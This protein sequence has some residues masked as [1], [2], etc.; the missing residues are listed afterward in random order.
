MTICYFGIYNPE[1]SRNRV[2]IKGL[3]QNSV[4][5][6]EC[7]QRKGF[8]KYI[9]LFLKHW[10]IRNSYDFMIVGFP[11]QSVVWLAR[12]ISKKPII[13]DAFASIYDSMVWDRKLAKPKSLK[14]LYYWFLD[15][16]SCHLADKILLDTQEHI[17]Y[18]IETFHLDPRKFYRIFVGTDEDIFYPRPDQ[19]GQDN[20]FLVHF[21]G[22]FIPLQGIEYIIKAAKILEKDNIKFN[23]IGKGQEYKKVIKLAND[24]NV[25][26]INFIDP[27]PY[28]K[29]IDYMAKADICLGIFGDTAKTRRVIPNKLYESLA[30][31]KAVITSNTKAAKELLIDKENCLLS[32][33][34]DGNSLAEKILE[35][36]NGPSLRRKIAQNG[37]ELF[38]RNATS[39]ILG[40]KL[41]NVLTGLNYETD[42]K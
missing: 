31:K 27:V 36:K 11:G 30:A 22:N 9:E 28:E 37:Y 4:E 13:F 24:L 39:E 42:K 8:W 26:N 16:L 7:N 10:K 33:I 3:K 18:F 12:L 25:N 19:E 21:H 1:Y 17:N 35:F 40:C 5:I 32:K 23:I 6:I 29:L 14:A 2:L 15:W 38:K 41:K 20:C 34:A